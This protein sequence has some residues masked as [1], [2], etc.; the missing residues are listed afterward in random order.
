MKERVIIINSE[1][2]L[3]VKYNTNKVLYRSSTGYP[4]DE[5]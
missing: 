4:I 2:E 1:N 5:N 3:K